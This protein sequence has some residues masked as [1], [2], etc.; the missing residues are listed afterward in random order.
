MDTWMPLPSPEMQ[1]FGEAFTTLGQTPG[2]AAL[3][4]LG[5]AVAPGIAEELLFRGLVL[6]SIKRHLST[7]WAVLIS[8][9]VFAAYH[10]NLQQLPTAFVIGLALGALAI[11]SG[12]VVPGMLLH[13]LH[14]G[15]ALGA[16]LYLDEETLMRPE[17]WLL[18]LGPAVAVAVLLKRKGDK[19]FREPNL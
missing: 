1:A 2:S 3:L 14:N 5:A 13:M 9:A 8:S 6:Q 19:G 4:F 15:L 18:L 11:R 7:K 16:Q 10:L 12:S 17:M